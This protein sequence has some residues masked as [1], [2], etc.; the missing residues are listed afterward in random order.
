[1]GYGGEESN[2]TTGMMAAGAA[3]GLSSGSGGVQQYNNLQGLH[4]QE[5]QRGRDAINSHSHQQQ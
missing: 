2:P 3:H 1:M 5:N 4:G